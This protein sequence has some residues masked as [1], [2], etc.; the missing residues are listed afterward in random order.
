[1]RGWI[2]AGL[3]GELSEFES[4]LLRGHLLRCHSCSEF[5]ADAAN[6]AAV[7]RHAPLEPL[8]RPIVLP[9]RRR[10][11]FA[12][13]RATAAAALA[14]SMIGVG[15][16]FASLHSGTILNKPN[17]Y[18]V[19]ALDDQELRQLQRQKPQAALAA[20]RARRQAFSASTEIPRTTG[21]QNP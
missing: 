12:P 9:H 17:A 6:L 1:M 20:L 14:V 5:K 4:V 13:L 3:D 8:S 11:A 18:A 19:A 15:G 10:I 7:L 16:L 21:F 2:S